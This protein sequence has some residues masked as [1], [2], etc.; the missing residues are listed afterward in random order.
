VLSGE[1]E[2]SLSIDTGEAAQAVRTRLSKQHAAIVR[3]LAG[4]EERLRS[5][6]FLDRAPAE[7]VQADRVRQQELSARR[8]VLERYLARLGEESPQTWGT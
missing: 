2:A 5:P 1:V 8:A 6:A 3:D 7:V 4:L